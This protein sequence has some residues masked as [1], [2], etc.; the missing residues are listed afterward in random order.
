MQLQSTQTATSTIL[1][2]DDNDAVRA[3]LSAQLEKF[4]Y[5]VVE[6][7]DGSDALRQFDDLSSE[8][9]VAILDF[10]MPGKDGFE[11]FK[12]LRGRNPE[13]PAILIT[14]NTAEIPHAALS[15]YAGILIVNKPFT[16]ITL[17]EEIQS[18]CIA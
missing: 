15:R 1:L 2:A 5:R 8:I 14:G 7:K 11:V 13:L 9:D 3:L 17:H 4:G 16:G 18:L 6:A 10:R 12:E